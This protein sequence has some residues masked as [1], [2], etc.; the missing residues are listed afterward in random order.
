MEDKRKRERR[1][2]GQ[3]GGTD[4]EKKRCSI[5]T[6]LEKEPFKIRYLKHPSF[7]RNSSYGHNEGEIERG[8][9][10]EEETE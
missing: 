10:R 6:S 4:V 8:R 1:G 7:T 5:C 2:E 9:K 3:M